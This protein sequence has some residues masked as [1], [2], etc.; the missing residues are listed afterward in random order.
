MKVVGMLDGNFELNTSDMRLQHFAVTN[1]SVCTGLAISCCNQPGY[2]AAT[3]ASCV[4][5]NFCEN[6]CLRNRI[7]SPQ[8]VA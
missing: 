5:E 3:N 7:L 6:L 4:L 1:H 2:V 8:K